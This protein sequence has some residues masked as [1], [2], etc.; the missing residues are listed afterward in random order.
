LPS[1]QEVAQEAAKELVAL[2]CYLGV[3]RLE[4]RE[5]VLKRDVCH[6]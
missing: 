5:A 4:R 3:L 2:L 6:E 1:P